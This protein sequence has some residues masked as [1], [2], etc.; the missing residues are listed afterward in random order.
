VEYLLRN[1]ENKKCRQPKRKKWVADS[2][3]ERGWQYKGYFD[4]RHGDAEFGVCPS[5]F[6]GFVLVSISSLW[7][8]PSPLE[9]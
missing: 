1:A 8:L 7:S 2:K 9:W 6:S 5:V 3:D 4:I